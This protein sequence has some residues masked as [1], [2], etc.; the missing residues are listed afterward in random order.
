MA[1]HGVIGVWKV[2][3]E[4]HGAEFAGEAGRGSAGFESINTFGGFHVP[5]V[6]LVA[7]HLAQGRV[8]FFQDLVLTVHVLGEVEHVL[9]LIDE[10]RGLGFAVGLC[11]TWGRLNFCD[12]RCR[13]RCGWNWDFVFGERNGSDDKGQGDREQTHPKSVNQDLD[14][15]KELSLFDGAAEQP[16]KKAITGFDRIDSEAPDAAE[17]FEDDSLVHLGFADLAVF[18]ND[19]EFDD[20]ELVEE[21]AVLEFDL[22]AVAIRAERFKIDGLEDGLAP[23]VKAAGEV[24]D[25]S[26][27]DDSGVEA[28]PTADDLAAD[29]PV[30]GAAAHDIA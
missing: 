28:P 19:R 4:G 16:A 21:G 30:D 29:A 23:A 6:F 7:F 22:E 26:V 1:G 8:I 15:K 9:G 3:W 24:A 2:Q 20:A 13:W 17:G 27:E 18:K 11:R 12:W 14:K 25:W 5:F 10:D